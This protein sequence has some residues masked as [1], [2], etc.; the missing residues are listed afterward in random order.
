MLARGDGGR[1]GRSH[2][3]RPLR[4]ACNAAKIVPPISF[5]ILRHTF[6]S[7]LARRRVPMAI[8]AAALGNSEAICAKHY[9]HLSPGYVADTIRQHAGG[10]GIVPAETNVQPMQPRV[11]GG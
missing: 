2:Q 5:H 4:E 10:M 1:W 11:Y 6:A 3:F 8:I 9:A 7:R